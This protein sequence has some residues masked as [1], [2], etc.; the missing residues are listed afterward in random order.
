MD[1]AQVLL[2]PVL[3]TISD[4]AQLVSIPSVSRQYLLGKNIF[5]PNYTPG[6]RHVHFTT[7]KFMHEN[8][9]IHNL[10]HDKQIIP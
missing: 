3:Y 9:F 4:M 1:M 7:I 5:M 2:A 8:N 10:C 6:G